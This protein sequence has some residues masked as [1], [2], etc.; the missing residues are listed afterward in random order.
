MQSESSQQRRQAAP[1]LQKIFEPEMIRLA[2]LEDKLG[3]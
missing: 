2:K 1:N 3:N